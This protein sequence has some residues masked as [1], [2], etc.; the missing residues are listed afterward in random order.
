MTWLNGSSE[1]Q[2]LN[3]TI[4]SNITY[5]VPGTPVCKY[6]SN[7]CYSRILHRHILLSFTIVLTICMYVVCAYHPTMYCRLVPK[8][9]DLFDGMFTYKWALYK[10]GCMIRGGMGYG[11]DEINRIIMQKWMSRVSVVYQVTLNCVVTFFK[12]IVMWTVIGNVLIAIYFP[13]HT[14]SKHRWEST[15]IYEAHGHAI[16]TTL[17][18]VQCWIAKNAVQHH[19]QEV[20]TYAIV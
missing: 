8:Y 17:T 5:Y 10:D 2:N 13:V 1:S 16:Y 12:S 19:R 20:T 3:P 15:H 7:Y 14:D 6:H 9:Y 18:E 4:E 11:V